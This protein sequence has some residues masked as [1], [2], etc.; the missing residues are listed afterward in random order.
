MTAWLLSYIWVWRGTFRGGILVLAIGAFLLLALSMRQ[1][2]ERLRDIA[3]QE[4]S[5]VPASI[6]VAQVLV[7]ALLLIVAASTY[8]GG[9]H[10]PSPATALASLLALMLFGVLQEYILLTFFYR[11][12][13]E[14]LGSSVP[15]AIA[16]A[17]LFALFHVPNPFLVPVT[18]VSGLAACWVYQRARNVPVIGVAHGILSFSLYYSLPVAVTHGLRVGPAV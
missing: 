8:S 12:A 11:R 6:R 3:S 4:G 16:A 1:N 7:P 17:T 10:F 5:L 15:A 13:V 2:G 14:L 18:F 9:A